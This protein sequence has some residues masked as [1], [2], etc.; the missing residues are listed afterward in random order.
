MACDQCGV[1]LVAVTQ[2]IFIDLQNERE[3]LF[4]NFLRHLSSSRKSDFQFGV[5]NGVACV[6]TSPISFVARGKGTSA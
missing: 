6:Q 2:L 3:L 5:G 1:W 4:C